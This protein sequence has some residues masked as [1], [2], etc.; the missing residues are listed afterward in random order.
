VA[1]KNVE[2]KTPSLILIGR[3]A[4]STACKNK[5]SRA[6]HNVQIRGLET[7]AAGSL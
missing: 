7:S 2:P 6:K 3:L 1:I 4:Y 5:K